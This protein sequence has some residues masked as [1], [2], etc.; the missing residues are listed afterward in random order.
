MVQYVITTGEQRVKR[1]PKDLSDETHYREEEEEHNA[2]YDHEAFLGKEQA[3]RFDQLEHAEAQRRLGYGNS[4]Q[5]LVR[6]RV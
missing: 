2:D 6:A 3:E 4:G 5:A 1:G